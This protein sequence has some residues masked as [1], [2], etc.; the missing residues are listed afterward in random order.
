MTLIPLEVIPPFPFFTDNNGLPLDGGFVYIGTENM[1]PVN[2][3]VQVFWDRDGLIP[4]DQPIRT[5]NGYP[6]RAGSPG[7][8]FC[9]TVYSMLVKN[10]SGITVFSNTSPRKSTDDLSAYQ[11][12]L[13]SSPGAGYIGF[14]AALSYA[15]GTV[16][17]WLTR[18]KSSA[19]SSLIGYLAPHTGAVAT[20]QAV[21]NS[22]TISLW[23]FMTSAQIADAKAGTLVFDMT[24]A[25]N[26]AIAALELF[27]GTVILPPGRYK[28]TSTIYNKSGVNLVGGGYQRPSGTPTW[29][30]TSSI[31]GVHTGAS[32]LSLKGAS[33]CRVEDLSLEGD[34]TTT[35]QTGLCLGRSSGASAGY[36]NISRV[37]VFG[38]FTKAAIY[39]IASEENFWSDVYVWVLTGAAKYAFYTSPADSLSVDS[40][41]TSTNLSNTLNRCSFLHGANYDV[42]AACIYMEVGQSMGSWSFLGCYMNAL[43]GSYIH[44]NFGSI[45]GT[46]TPIGPFTFAGT[47]GERITDGDP[48]YG[49][50]LSSAVAVTVPGLTFIGSRFDLKAEG[51]PSTG[52]VPAVIGSHYTIYQDPLLTLLTPNIVLQPCEASP[53]AADGL[54]RGQIYGGLVSYGR[55]SIWAAPTLAGTWANANGAPYAQAGYCMDSNGVVRLRGTVAAGTGLIMTLP[56]GFRPAPNMYF[57]VNAD[58][59][60]GRVLVGGATGA[61]PGT[62]TLVAGTSAVNV[63]LSSIQFNSI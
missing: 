45:D 26:A 62:V 52:G 8:V 30:G 50:R 18:L 56:V 61:N 58:G 25:V 53:Y 12:L 1:D 63:D 7:Q 32:V 17:E 35:P 4:A 40:M 51:A 22:T 36:H 38:A 57:N 33:G 44:M 54:I 49:I 60:V 27:G 14:N 13:A 2:N 16:G 21:K 3:P 28:T 55:E 48:K 5:I 29:Q 24:S 15:V 39:S 23:D 11:A 41:A 42:D 31:Y 47:S 46:A 34:W 37:G 43:V 59:A 9:N 6:S 19:G 10:K 20:T